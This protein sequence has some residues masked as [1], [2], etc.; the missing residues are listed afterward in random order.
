MN[1]VDVLILDDQFENIELMQEYILLYCKI[2]G[3]V[4]AATTV[5]EAVLLYLKYEPNIFFLDVELEGSFTSFDFLKRIPKNNFQVVF[6]TSHQDYALKAINDVSA[7][8]YLMKPLKPENL[9]FALD[10]AVKNLE[11]F[12]TNPTISNV[13]LSAK[14][15]VLGISLKDRV[16]LMKQKEIVYME[17]DGKYT[18]FFLADKSI[19]RSSKNIGDYETL[20]DPS[21]YFRIHKKY[22]VNLSYVTKIDKTAGNYC[23]FDGFKSLPVSKRRQKELYDFLNL[24]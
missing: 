15:D 21:I 3:N 13:Q 6:I 22:V 19:C 2:I 5:D 23:E 9:V 16:V 4:Y 11:N 8:A 18:N 7:A 14:Y 17:A 10:K 20:L 1:K 24:N 12:T